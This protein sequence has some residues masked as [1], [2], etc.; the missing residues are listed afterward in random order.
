MLS[1]QD[2]PP[3]FGALGVIGVGG[4]PALHV[5]IVVKNKNHGILSQDM[6]IT[7]KT[8]KITSSHYISI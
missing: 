3:V 1:L 2:A 7:G 8:G 6:H 4:Q 5:Y